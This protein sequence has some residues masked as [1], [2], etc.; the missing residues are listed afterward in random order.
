MP[1]C[2]STVRSINWWTGLASATRARIGFSAPPTSVSATGPAS[3]SKSSAG[4]SEAVA[5]NLGRSATG[6]TSTGTGRGSAGVHGGAPTT[7]VRIASTFSPAARIVARRLRTEADIR[8]S[9]AIAPV[10]EIILSSAGTTSCSRVDRT[11]RVTRVALSREST[12]AEIA[13]SARWMRLA[14]CRVLKK[15]SAAAPATAR[16]AATAASRSTPWTCGATTMARNAAAKVG[17]ASSPIRPNDSSIDVS[18]TPAA[19]R[20]ASMPSSTI[21]NPYFSSG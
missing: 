12:A 9:V 15:L 14:A 20:G 17:R 4:S 5:E 2:A 21:T 19:R 8:R 11:E 13:C 6:A 3:I 10:A 1:I 18:L 7:P 16:A